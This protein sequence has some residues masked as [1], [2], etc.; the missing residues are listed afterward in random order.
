MV[1]SSLVRLRFVCGL[2][3]LV[4]LGDLG[5]NAGEHEDLLEDKAP[6]EFLEHLV[7]L[8]PV[9]GLPLVD[10]VVHEVAG[11][12]AEAASRCGRHRSRVPSRKAKRKSF[13][14]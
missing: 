1:V 13:F 6:R 5:D 14:E 9:P 2:D 8:A 10:E 4:A 12:A 11:A 7:G 3:G